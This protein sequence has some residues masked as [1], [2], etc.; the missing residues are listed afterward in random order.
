MPA[1]RKSQLMVPVQVS[2]KM[3]E[4]ELLFIN[5]QACKFLMWHGISDDWTLGGR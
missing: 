5:H 1:E 4:P 2:D 3:M